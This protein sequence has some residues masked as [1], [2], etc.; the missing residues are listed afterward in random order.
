MWRQK[1]RRKKGAV[2]WS[3]RPLGS[4]L[5]GYQLSQRSDG[6]LKTI[7]L[8]FGY[9]KL[10]RSLLQ[11]ARLGLRVN[12]MNL[13]FPSSSD[14]FSL[15]HS[16]TSYLQLTLNVLARVLTALDVKCSTDIHLTMMLIFNIFIV[17]FHFLSVH[18]LCLNAS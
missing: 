14:S 18:T 9:E 3:L 5:D 17:T 10:H 7:R 6:R 12:H 16:Q 1:R 15:V 8:F 4:G 13:I 11:G 2:W